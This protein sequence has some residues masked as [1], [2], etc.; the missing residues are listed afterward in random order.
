ML[1]KQITEKVRRSYLERKGDAQASTS[2]EGRGKLRKSAG[3]RKQELIRRCPNGTT[4]HIE[5]MSHS[6]NTMS[7][8]RELKHLSICSKRKKRIDFLSSGERKGNSPNLQCYGIAG[9]TGSGHTMIILR[10]TIW[11]N[12]RQSVTATYSQR[13][14]KVTDILSKAGHEESCLNSRGPPRKAKQKWKTDSEP[15][16]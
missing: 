12:R 2:E 14:I 9:V 11:K 3:I 1:N 5:D 15:V 7:R 13:I 6:S 10:G 8:H 16:L 4:R